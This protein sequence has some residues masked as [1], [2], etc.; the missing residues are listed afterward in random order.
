MKYV[1]STFSYLKKNF[2]LPLAV[3][4]IPSV[5]ACF[6]STPYWEVS[7]VTAFDYDPYVSVGK[8][9]NII[10]GDSWQYLW[11]V[12]VISI[13]QIVGATLITSAIGA[14]FRTGRLS[15]KHPFRLVNTAIFPMTV[16]VIVMCAVSIVWRFILFGLTLLAGVVCGA[17]GMP[18][19]AALAVIAVI[20][21]VM[22]FFHVLMITPMLYWAPVMAFYGYRFRDAAAASFKLIAGKK[23]FRGLFLPMLLCAAIQ[24]LVGFLDV[25]VSIARVTSFIMFLVTNA[26]V[27]VYI[28]MSFYKISG[29]DRRDVLPYELSLPSPVKPAVTQSAANEPPKTQPS[30]EKSKPT[31]KKQTDKPSQNGAAPKKQYSKT[32]SASKGAATDKKRK[33]SVD[34]NKD[35][36]VK[37]GTGGE[38]VV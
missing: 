24:L 31:P 7:F 21:V 13:F 8:T 28:V 29:L 33:K 23:V 5:V 37:D 34:T 4:I 16:C 10:F 35:T 26:Y 19:G 36:T 32:K 11:P 25:H 38:D 3:M 12:I 1:A 2:W 14:H 30:A 15:L 22:F 17:I 18:P 6:L 27:P 20:A 9:F